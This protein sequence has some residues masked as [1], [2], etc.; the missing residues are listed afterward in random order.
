[1]LC[2]CVKKKKKK[3]KPSKTKQ[4]CFHQCGTKWIHC[5]CFSWCCFSLWNA[6]DASEACQ[7]C[8]SST[9]GSVA[10]LRFHSGSPAAAG[11][12]A[13]A[14]GG[15]EMGGEEVTRWRRLEQLFRVKMAK[16]GKRQKKTWIKKK[17][18]T[19]KR[20][21]KKWVARMRR[22][23]SLDSTLGPIKSI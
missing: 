12:A 17:K 19:E 2:Y 9:G 7:I 21:S 15:R 11:S 23:D 8:I 22:R 18:K 16:R 13:S 14:C 3:R 4:L 10:P 20:H 5:C 6:T 1:M